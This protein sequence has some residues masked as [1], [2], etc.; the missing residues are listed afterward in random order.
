MNTTLQKT[1]II[2]AGGSGTRMKSLQPKQFLRLKN[3]PLLMHT[4]RVFYDWDAS[5]SIRLVLPENQMERWNTLCGEFNFTLP[6]QV[7]PGG[8]TRFYSV[9]NALHGLS[10]EGLVAVHDGVRPLVS[11][12]TIAGAF[13]TAVE[14]G[15]AVPVVPLTE[16][17]REIVDSGTISR[18]RKHY[19]SVQTPQVF[20]SEWL[21]KAYQ[22]AY[23]EHF[24]DD[25]SVVEAAGY[26]IHTCA[27][28]DENIKVTSPKDLL[29]A[30]S[31]IDFAG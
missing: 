30:A 22:T 10:A 20:R 14:Q 7:I 16:S 8:D 13:Q 18:P 15:S 5:I 3:T 1:V 4:M 2:V 26:T 21:L 29:I 27:G 19:L 25:A 31:L 24:T 17:V 12:K 6:H 23:S 9:K 28:N 11:Q